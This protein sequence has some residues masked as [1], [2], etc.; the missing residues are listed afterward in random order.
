M[1]FKKIS[2]ILIIYLV[3]TNLI[4]QTNP[5]T[6]QGKAKIIGKVIENS[7]NHNLV[8]ATV[9]IKDT[10][11]RFFFGTITDE[12]GVFKFNKIPKGDYE[13]SVSYIGY[14]PYL[15]KISLSENTKNLDLG[16]IKL[17]VSAAM[18]KEIAITGEKIIIEDKLDRLEYNV[19]NDPNAEGK[20]ILEVFRNIP[21]VNVD[22]EDK[23]ELKGSSHIQILIDGKFSTITQNNA[24]KIL[25]ALPAN[26]VKS[27]EVITSPS[28][29]YDA[30]NAT[31][32]INIIT[33]RG[34]IKDLIGSYYASLGNRANNIGSNV[35]Y[36]RGKLALA[37][38]F[39][40]GLDILRGIDELTRNDLIDNNLFEQ[41]TNW[42]QRTFDQTYYLGFD[43]NLNEKNTLVFN[44][45]LNVI[46]L[47]KNSV[48][49]NFINNQ[50]NL[51]QRLDY[52]SKNL[53][54]NLQIGYEKQFKRQG[55][56]LTFLTRYQQNWDRNQDKAQRQTFNTTEALPNFE[57][58]NPKLFQETTLQLD[59]VLPFK[60]K[61]NW[62]IGAKNILRSFIIDYEQKYIEASQINIEQS[63]FDFQQYIYAGYSTLQYQI[64]KKITTR[65]GLRIEHTNNIFEDTQNTNYT[66]LIPNFLTSYKL[67]DKTTIK[68][69]LSK[70]IQRPSIYLLNPFVNNL[71]SNNI[72][73]G[74][75][76]LLPEI[77]N[78]YDLGIS[79]FSKKWN[80]NFSVY[81]RFTRD[82]IAGF[83]SVESNILTT[84]YQNLGQRQN[85]GASLNLMLL[86]VKNLRV[87][88]AGDIS[89]I[90][91]Q[92]ADFRRSGWQ[93]NVSCNLIYSINKNIELQFYNFYVAPKIIYQ[94]NSQP[95]Y[96]SVFSFVKRFWERKAQWALRVNNPFLQ[97]FNNQVEISETQFY[98]F[99][100]NKSYTPWA[101]IGLSLPLGKSKTDRKNI[102]KI[103]N[104]DLKKET[105]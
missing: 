36:G 50:R 1:L 76:L 81:Y 4:A 23:I 46:N 99:F 31:G 9:T 42:K 97:T 49:D 14:Q 60:N 92:N 26:T 29:K 52:N 69:S 20:N 3:T 32:I 73:V 5:D 74:N 62:E 51:F 98:Q 91:I 47:I 100:V 6:L 12:N 56:T 77:T 90:F 93:G 83:R 84:R 88:I 101:S 82:M 34:L 103:N 37:G 11:K 64:N 95:S 102:K 27:I 40:L 85:Y 61:F 2:F 33:K 25:K 104:Q 13:L 19:Q 16:I 22:A 105:D 59:Y 41:N 80:L 8:Y 72:Q 70:S 10:I 54:L 79:R 53:E 63:G 55:N 94:G 24:A 48:S 58:Q 30:E 45:S 35:L 44:S 96:F 71:D 78:I 17:E 66:N 75:R 38:G 89:Y 87:I 39:N 21:Y 15:A 7:I 43:Y 28:A 86:W 18:L 57:L 67:N 65:V 68:F